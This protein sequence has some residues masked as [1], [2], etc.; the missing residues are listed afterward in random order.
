MAVRTQK[1]KLPLRTDPV[2]ARPKRVSQAR[3][4]SL[5]KGTGY[6]RTVLEK[7]DEERAGQ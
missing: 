7:A 1:K 2:K 6:A 3:A 4:E 5:R